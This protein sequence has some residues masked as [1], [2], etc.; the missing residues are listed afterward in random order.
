M[1][2]RNRRHSEI[3]RFLNFETHRSARCGK[4][5]GTLGNLLR[6]PHFPAG[7]IGARMVE[8]LV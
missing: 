1:D 8:K 2:G 3:R 5:Y 7:Q 6:R 4:P